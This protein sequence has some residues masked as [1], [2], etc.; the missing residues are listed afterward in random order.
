MIVPELQRTLIVRVDG[1]EALLAQG[2]YTGGEGEGV[3]GK[4]GSS[5]KEIAPPSGR[6]EREALI[7]IS[8]PVNGSAILQSGV[9]EAPW[10]S[11]QPLQPDQGIRDTGT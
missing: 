5:A 1:S 11:T 6:G 7:N 3:L 2:N 8:T 9:R 10:G 4:L